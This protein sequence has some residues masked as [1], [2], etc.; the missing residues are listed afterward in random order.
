MAVGSS[1]KHVHLRK[2][3]AVFFIIITINASCDLSKIST[4]EMKTLFLL[5]TV[6]TSCDQ[7]TS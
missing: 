7:T 2:S 4:E 3:A 1:N 6:Q 5:K